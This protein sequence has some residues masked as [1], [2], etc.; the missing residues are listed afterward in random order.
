M[1]ATPLQILLEDAFTNIIVGATPTTGPFDFDFPFFSEADDI[2]VKRTDDA[3]GVVTDLTVTT[4]YTVQG[5]SVQGGF[6]GGTITLV[7]SDSDATLLIYRDI[8]VKR[9]DWFPDAGPFDITTLNQTLARIFAISQ[10][11]NESIDRGLKLPITE[12]GTVMQVPELADRAN[13]F[14]GFD[15]SGAAIA[16]T[17]VTGAVVSTFMETVLDDLNSSTALTTL[18]MNAARAQALG[19]ASIEDVQASGS[20]DLLR[21][22][23]NAASLTG[24]ELFDA[25]DD[26]LI[27][28]EL[29]N[30]IRYDSAT[31]VFVSEGEATDDSDTAIMALTSALSKQIDSAWAVG[32]QA[33]WL[34]TGSVASDTWYH[35]FLIRR[36]DTGVVD[37]LCSLSPTAPTM[38]TNYDQKRCIGRVL[39]ETSAIRPFRQDGDRFLWDVPDV[40]FFDTNPAST[41]TTRVLLV[42]D[43]LKIRPIWTLTLDGQTSPTSDGV[44]ATS[45]DQPDTTPARAGPVTVLAW[46][47]NTS[48]C[49]LIDHLWTDESSS[50]RTRNV[51]GGS[52]H[53][54][55]GTVHGWI[56]PR[57][58]TKPAKPVQKQTARIYAGTSVSDSTVGTTAWVNPTNAQGS[59][60]DVF[61]TNTTVGSG[62]F[63]YLKSTNYGFSIP[64]G[65][66]ITG[67]LV[68]HSSKDVGTTG[69]FDNCRLVIGGAIGTGIRDGGNTSSTEVIRSAGGEGD[70]FDETLTPAIINASDFGWVLGGDTSGVTVIS[71]DWVAMTIYYVEVE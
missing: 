16:S 40:S 30:D 64:A 60:D 32:D 8:G 69:N 56:D 34:D 48:D 19:A 12:A 65:A 59:D 24:I 36:S 58:R 9:T 51:A 26:H 42:P 45:L 14:L 71:T 5:T 33:G 35:V 4:E 10:E 37:C 53:D 57:G 3:T 66:T 39:Y 50:V 28:L 62:T 17:A 1:A 38:P 70:V 68:E 46:G 61:A 6:Q 23:G 20:G 15:A 55:F 22:D 63:E 27:G 54:T 31:D 7:S 29:A 47:N 2:K 21:E 44:L 13:K 67:V 25:S 43:G 41:A 52:L 18:G 49:A 11:I